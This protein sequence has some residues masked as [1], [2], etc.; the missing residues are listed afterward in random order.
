MAIYQLQDSPTLCYVLCPLPA[1]S[2]PLGNGLPASDSD[3]RPSPE[4]WRKHSYSRA[5]GEPK[6][7][8]QPHL[9]FKVEVDAHKAKS[10]MPAGNHT[11]H[12]HARSPF[13]KGTECTPPRWPRSS[14]K[15]QFL[16][17]VQ[18]SCKKGDGA[19]RANYF[20]EH[21]YNRKLN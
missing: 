2:C 3:S 13:L 5:V 9:G 7:Q 16:T 19:N 11:A 10:W 12:S 1:V 20:Y 4:D 14:H 15:M 21:I 18:E 8:V 6:T 17:Q